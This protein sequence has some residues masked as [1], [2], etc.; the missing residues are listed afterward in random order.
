[1]TKSRMLLVIMFIALAYP[2]E[3]NSS[4]K[5]DINAKFF[6]KSPGDGTTNYYA[7]IC[8]VASY[9]YID[10]LYYCD[11]DARD[12]KSALLSTDNWTSANIT[13]LTNSAATKDAIQTA[14]QNMATR[15]DGDDVCL[16]FFSGHG[17]A[18]DDILPVDESD[19]YDEYICPY[20]SALY[21]WS[22]DIRD[23]DF[24]NWIAEL[25]TDKY[26][27]LLDTCY[28]GGQIK[29]KTPGTDKGIQKTLQGFKAALNIT[30][31]K[32]DGFAADLFPAVSAKDLDDIGRGVVITSCDDDETSWE[33]PELQHGLFTY[34]LLEA[35]TGAADADNDNSVS[36]EECYSYAT[37]LTTDYNS[38]QHPQLYNG[39]GSPLNFIFFEPVIRKCTVKAGANDF[40]DKITFSGVIHSFASDFDGTDYAEIYIYSDDMDTVSLTFPVI[41]GVTFKNDKYRYSGTDSGTK[42]SFKYST[43]T[44]KFS[45]SASK[46]NLAGLECPFTVEISIGD[47]YGEI[48]VD[49][50]IAN[51]KKPLPIN[52]LMGVKNKL[53]VDKVILKR[54]T[55]IPNTSRLSIKGGFSVQYPYDSNLA[56]DNFD[57]DLGGQTFHIP[58][59]NFK[60]NRRGD[61]FTCSKYMIYDEFLNLTAIIS[62]DFNFRKC[63][64]T[65][66]IKNTEISSG[67]GTTALTII[68][69]YFAEVVDIDL[70]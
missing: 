51:R 46:V 45:F 6:A 21:S 57:V 35:M 9:K 68:F 24:S 25:P 55:T 63:T 36:A 64:F 32:G 2:A 48:T 7:V 22:K 5:E 47:F 27:I 15:A 28:A 53:R 3:H 66:T 26:I 34:Y 12:I 17:G 8:G 62:A 40:N 50:A 31:R 61:R 19:G 52:L 4:A 11:D 10:N 39:Y 54:G 69:P 42:K 59:G 38:E 44:D 37:P 29:A 18:G 43:K 13:L 67:P 14:I 20:D 60:A 16:F 70:P 33:Y 23:D 58:A 1:M 30:P 41:D 49:E 56:A 65:L